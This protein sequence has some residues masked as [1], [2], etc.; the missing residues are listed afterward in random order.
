MSEKLHSNVLLIFAFYY[1]YVLIGTVGA[2]INFNSSTVSYLTVL[3]G[4][5][6][7]YLLVFLAIRKNDMRIILKAS[8]WAFFFVT[9]YN[10]MLVGIA[11][12]IIP[13]NPL[14]TLDYTAAVG[15]HE[16]Y[17]H[18]TSTNTSMF[19]LLYPLF[20]TAI[21]TLS[22]K[23][24]KRLGFNNI[25][26]LI[27]VLLSTICIILTGRRILW[28]VVGL[29][30]IFNLLFIIRKKYRTTAIFVTMIVCICFVYVL[31]RK[32][33]LT[34]LINRL[35]AAFDENSEGIRFEQIKYLWQYF[36]EQPFF[37]HGFAVYFY[38]PSYGVV[39]II[40]TSYSLMLFNVGIVG[41]VFYCLFYFGFVG[42]LFSIKTRNKIKYFLKQYAI[43]ALLIAFFANATNPYIGSSFDFYIF[44]FLPFFSYKF[45]DIKKSNKLQL[46]NDKNR[47]NINKQSIEVNNVTF[48]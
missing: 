47:F 37:G 14:S 22:K 32:G 26:V 30:I 48:Y 17:V 33:I 4:W 23:Q 19:I 9:L 11:Y 40:E 20:F 16:G 15:I 12:N 5:F 36:L 43:L 21:I 13:D 18:I 6:S 8:F 3:I 28:I 1:I 38:L 45:F 41:T 24:F 35:V 31:A 2:L 39:N 42:I 34:G 44:I 27:T 29:T 7:L 25:A 10:L 46:I